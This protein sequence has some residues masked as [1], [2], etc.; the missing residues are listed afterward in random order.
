MMLSGPA[1]LRCTLTSAL[2]AWIPAVTVLSA[3]DRPVIWSWLPPSGGAVHH[4][5][6][7]GLLVLDTVAGE[8]GTS[9]AERLAAQVRAGR[10]PGDRIGVVMRHYGRRMPM[11]AYDPD[12]AVVVPSDLQSIA[13]GTP[14]IAH[15]L[16]KAC[17]WT[18]AFIAEY[19]RIQELEGLP[20][21]ARFHMDCEL[22]LPKLCYQDTSLADCWSERPVRLFDA[23]V[24]DPRWSSESVPV[25]QPGGVVWR[26]VQ[27]M[28][29]EAGAPAWDSSQPRNAPVNRGWSRWYDAMQRSVM[30]GAL[31][32]AFYAP[33]RAAWPLCRSSEFAQSI[34]VDGADEPGGR[35]VFRDFEWWLNGWMDSAWHGAGDLQA[36]TI[37]AFGTSFMEPGADWVDANIRLDRANLD[38]CLH[39]FGG[40]APET[41]TPWIMLPGTVLPI[42][43]TSV[44]EADAAMLEE[45]LAIL[46]WRGMNEFQ[47]WP[48]ASPAIW[49]H[50]A[51]TVD[52]VWSSDIVEVELP[53][54]SARSGTSAAVLGR[55][56]RQSCE[57]VSA[58]DGIE[59]R[60]RVKGDAGAAGPCAHDRLLVHLEGG[61]A[62]GSVVVEAALAADPDQGWVRLGTAAVVPGG[63]TGFHRWWLEDA[64]VCVGTDGSVLLRAVVD[65]G[66]YRFDL[67]R[68]V[69]LPDVGIDLDGSG[70]VDTGDLALALLEF[71]PTA[72]GAADIDGNGA[73]DFGD[74][75]LILLEFGGC[76]G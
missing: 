3:T 56:D 25:S 23:I 24:A 22:R 10:L 48:G 70:A 57:V 32:Q 40:A 52:S 36:P 47:L 62:V 33:V 12:D 38:A 44:R 11:L 55:A 28:H 15:G 67:F 20:S 37:Y 45:R 64:A 9:F 16:P 51:R 2:A 61:G 5:S 53:H 31:E 65:G 42:D 41:V 14:W 59:L 26:T 68:A 63:V 69:R 75:A 4:P 66:S 46:R 71:G 39:S 8:S 60:V 27:Q 72:G 30:D 21:P 73:V 76:E 74:L 1:R 34:R 6:F 17:A 7:R 43:T 35:R 13:T 54:G 29:Q 49:T 58:P 18:G 19:R 50:V